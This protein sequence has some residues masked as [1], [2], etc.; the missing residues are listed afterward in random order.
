M[1]F[2]IIFIT[3]VSFCSSLNTSKTFFIFWFLDENLFLIISIQ[4][5]LSASLLALLHIS[6][7][8]SFFNYLFSYWKKL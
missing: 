2:L 4:F 3:I 1:K 6:I 7:K 5:L 8:L